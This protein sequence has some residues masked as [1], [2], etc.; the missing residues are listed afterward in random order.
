ML[1]S[2]TEIQWELLLDLSHDT[3]PLQIQTPQ[4]LKPKQR[5][6]VY[7]F[8]SFEDANQKKVIEE[9]MKTY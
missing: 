7:W 8:Y 3:F 1:D 2:L 4:C 6:I 9:Q 5:L